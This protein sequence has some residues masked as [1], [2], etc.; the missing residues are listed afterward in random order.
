M[1]DAPS[2][3]GYIKQG[4]KVGPFLRLL[5]V[6]ILGALL[7]M[8]V[9]AIAQLAPPPS[10]RQSVDS[11]GVDLF[12]GT[13]NIDAP[14]LTIGQAE[15]QG[16]SYYK[17]M[18][19]AGWSDNLIATINQTGSVITV[20]LGGVSDSFNVSGTTYTSTEGNGST[21]TLNNG[22]VYSYTRADGMVA[23]FAIAL[24]TPGPYYANIARISALVWPS[25]EILNFTYDS[26]T[27][28]SAY[29]YFPEARCIKR[30]SAKRVATVQNAYGYK[31]VFGYDVP[32]PIDPDQ[33]YSLEALTVWSTVTSVTASNLAIV[34]GGST[35]SASY[36][37]STSGGSNYQ[38]V[39]DALNRRTTY[40]TD[41]S[42]K[43]L[44]I[45]R[46]GSVTEDV[47]IAYIGDKVS[48]VTTSVGSTGYAFSDVAGVRT[49]TVTDPLSHMWTYTFDI[50]SKRMLSMTSPCRTN[51]NPCPTS[52]LSRTTN[53]QYYPNWLVKRIVQPE[54]HTTPES[55]YTEFTYDTY[56]RGNIIDTVVVPK[57]N[58]GLLPIATH[59]S[60][61]ASCTVTGVNYKT[62]NQPITTTDA[63]GK[64]TDYTYDLNSGNVATITLPAPVSTPGAARPRVSCG[65]PQ[66]SATYKNSNGVLAFGQP[67]RKLGVIFFCHV[68]TS[69][70]SN[71]PDETI[72]KIEYG[73]QNINIG[74]NLLPVTKR[75]E[76]NGAIIPG[77]ITYGY[78]DLGNQ[79]TVDGMLPGAVDTTRTRYDAARQVVGVVGPNPSPV[80][81]T[82]KYGA[83]RF[84]YDGKG[85]V[86]LAERGTVDSQSD[87]HWALFAPLQAVETTYDGV[88]QKLTETATA[89]GTTYGLTQY[90]YDAAS[91]LDCVAVR[92]TFTST[93]SS[94]CTQTMGATVP[95]RITRQFYDNA[96]QLTSV[97][98]GYATAL[99][100]TEVTSTY[101]GNGQTAS[102]ADARNNLTSYTYDGFDRLKST[103]FPL[104]STPGSSSPTD[105]IQTTLY[106]D[107]SNPKTI[108][109]RDGQT[110]SLTYDFLNRLKTKD[111]PGSEPDVTYTYDLTNRVLGVGQGGLSLSFTYDALDRNL[112]QTGP[113]G[114]LTFKYDEAGRRIRMDWP[115]PF[116]VTYDYLTTGQ[117]SCLVPAFDGS[118]RV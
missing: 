49:T 77:T 3:S 21:L 54:G 25:G 55:N 37:S 6:A 22:I 68:T 32:P 114:T 24:A 30:S 102:V 67:V 101:T 27:Y 34:S 79:V 15:P 62:C 9:G 2:G 7:C 66:M 85:R 16:L 8:P 42:S 33:P 64:V 98:S 28:C 103:C 17:L 88:D 14:A 39:D 87:A 57:L 93:E 111:L 29:E 78:D 61:P 75:Y 84:T 69:S 74:N 41:T 38:N 115:D 112:T 104:P 109:Q 86:T 5:Q 18:R 11:N 10:V 106:D 96:N 47:V 71:G 51:D 52:A 82:L 81:Y 99:A 116:Y 31:M 95:D 26:I 4:V 72:I 44:G 94:A 48:S 73:P 35:T 23:N 36:S 60:F 45:K 70:C 65:Y 80:G 43:L 50:A 13:M 12:L 92:L 1:A 58:S 40:R 108:V 110:I 100:R 20:S 90:T 117:V 113:Q 97:Q 46:P 83:T 91:R 59:A 105:C 53:W 107:N 118:D 63:N 56:G 89:G 76:T 19:G